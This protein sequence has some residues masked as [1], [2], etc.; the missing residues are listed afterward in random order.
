MHD[1]SAPLL[2]SAPVPSSISLSNHG[3]QSS[4]I[5]S[6]FVVY[7]DLTQ[8]NTLLYC[9]PDV[10]SIP[11]LEYAAIPSGSHNSTTTDWCIFSLNNMYGL[12]VFSTVE[13]PSAARFASTAAVGLISAS[14]PFL[15]SHVD[16]LMPF[17]RKFARVATSFVENDSSVVEEVD[18]I[19][20]LVNEVFDLAK[21]MNRY[22]GLCVKKFKK[23]AMII[24]KLLL[25][26]RNILILPYKG[27]E[28]SEICELSLCLYLL[29]AVSCSRYNRKFADNFNFLG[30][31]SL[32]DVNT[33]QS[34]RGFVACSSESIFSDHPDYS[35][36]FDLVI[37]TTPKG[38]NF[39]GEL[40]FKL[41]KSD[42]YLLSF[43]K[44]KNV[45][46]FIS[47][48]DQ[49]FSLFNQKCITNAD[50]RGIGLVVNDLNFIEYFINCFELNVEVSLNSKCCCCCCC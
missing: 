27:Q 9:D 30:N 10:P 44:T 24:R 25:S 19:R 32:Y 16:T 28:I 42:E 3:L 18:S 12:S 37:E 7:F 47:Q 26:K 22:F 14:I 15:I 35:R 8:G 31:I 34:T 40:S 20:S 5:Y 11:K 41:T 17:S 50:L 1:E 13:D 29:S 4:S 23:N 48:N 36:F 38:V 6:I 21:F 45:L 49:F 2:T 46:S 39:E 33:I 43:L